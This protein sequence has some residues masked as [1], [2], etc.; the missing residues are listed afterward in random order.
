[1]ALRAPYAM[2]S[3]NDAY[4]AMCPL[5]TKRAYGGTSPG[6]KRVHARMVGTG[7]VRIRTRSVLSARM[8]VPG[9]AR[10]RTMGS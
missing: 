9:A 3:T 10:I 8:A 7:A 2:P 6:T 5:G 1:M 4:G